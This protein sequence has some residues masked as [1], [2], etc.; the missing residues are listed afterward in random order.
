MKSNA[1]YRRRGSMY[2]M[3]LGTSM[4][5]TIIGLSALMVVRIQRYW[6]EGS[7]DLIQARLYAQ[8]AIDIGLHR[9]NED[10]DWRNTYPSGVWEADRPIGNGTYTLEGVDPDDDNL[11]D[12]DADPVVL[13][14]IGAQGEARY[15][16]Q[17]TLVSETRALTCLEVAFNTGGDLALDDAT[18][19]CNQIVSSNGSVTGVAA[20]QINGNLEAYGTVIGVTVS[21]STTTGITKR[22]M[23]DANTV[24]D[25]YIDIANGTPIDINTIPD[26]HGVYTISG[27]VVSPMSNPF[28]AGTTNPKGIYIID[29]KGSSLAIEDSRIVGTLVILNGSPTC[30]YVQGTVNWEPAV[31]NY[32]ALLV[33]GPLCLYMDGTVPLDEDDADTSFNPE[34][35]PYGDPG[36]WDSDTDDTYPSIITGVVYAESRLDVASSP[37]VDGVVVVGD[38]ANVAPFTV[39]DLTFDRT[40]LD[41]PPPGFTDSAGMV[42]AE[43]SWKRVVD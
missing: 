32:P 43:G 6:A 31:S 37:V 3:V 15:K 14:G 42:I 22:A 1:Q 41:N 30:S 35:T 34:G 24:Y 11:K 40:Y 16:L 38:N 25:H 7:N 39:L 2:L 12:D 26:D 19:N 18:V 27:V 4:A 17:V 8:S 21:G 29:V 5:V 33:Q 28:G 9:I 13:T 20:S 36:N 10:P 23:P